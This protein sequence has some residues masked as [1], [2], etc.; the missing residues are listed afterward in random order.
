MLDPQMEA[1]LFADGAPRHDDRARPPADA[2]LAEAFATV[3]E[4][5]GEAGLDAL[6]AEIVRKRDGLRDFIDAVGATATAFRPL[7]DEFGF[8]PGRDAPKASRHRSGRCRVSCRTIFARLRQR[9]RSRRRPHR[10]EQHPALCRAWPLPRP[11]RSGGC[12]LLAQGLPQGRRR[13]LRSGKGVQEGAARPAA[14]SARTLSGGRSTRSSRSSDRL[15]LFRM[16]EGTRAA[17]TIADWLIA[18]YEQLKRG[19]GFL[20]FN[21]L[22]TRT[23]RL[24]ARPG[25]RTLGAIQARPGHRPHPARRGA[26]HQPRP[27]GGGE[28]AG[29]R[30]LCRRTARATT[31]TARSLP[32][33]TKS[34]RS[35]P[36]RA[37]RRNPS[38]TAGSCSAGR[39]RDA[40]AVFD[41]AQADL[42]VPLDRRRACRRRPRLCRARA[43]GAASA[44]IP[45]R[46]TTRRS[47]PTRRAMSRS[48]RRS[49][50]T[51]STSPTTGR[52]PI[53]HATRAGGARRRDMWRRP[54]QA[55]STTGEIIEGT[56]QE[57]DGPATCWCWCAS[58]T[59]SSMRCRAR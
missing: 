19:R 51:P 11:I 5:G 47:A 32:S 16:L 54:S 25:C 37:R 34:S 57:A 26:G 42:V 24:L 49:A 10:A 22:I 13:P 38:P 36:S 4:R 21:D 46:S 31:S 15:A 30:V 1:S 12:R 7:F 33:A 55:G 8:A 45:I 27:V 53:D 40:D 3:L 50:P 43:C 23:V 18:R 28:A 35:I 41:R 39:V 59:A 44:T 58:A 29:G 17:L 48:G 56:R 9:R 14:R 20:D 6:L 2:G 52:K